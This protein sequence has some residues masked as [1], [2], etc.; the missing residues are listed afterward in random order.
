MGSDYFAKSPFASLIIQ[1]LN[2]AH[3]SDCQVPL[4]MVPFLSNK[5]GWDE[6][7]LPSLPEL[8]IQCLQE[9]KP[10]SCM[11]IVNGI[12][13]GPELILEEL[14]PSWREFGDKYSES[15]CVL[16]FS[17]IGLSFARLAHSAS[18]LF[19]SLRDNLVSPT[20]RIN[21]FT[22]PFTTLM[23]LLATPFG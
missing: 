6:Q 20:T 4:L 2:H 12:V 15:V 3:I 13:N 16:G 9:M 19:S 23:R 21:D 1:I 18:R 14:L 7:L 11:F 10:R 22:I 17:P 8:A 5:H